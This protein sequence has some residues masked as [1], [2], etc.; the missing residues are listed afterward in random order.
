[1]VQPGHTL[2]VLRHAKSAWP[3]G[4]ADAARPL[5][6][7]GE[8]DAPAVG[9]WLRAHVPGID[10]TVC[11]PAARTRQ[12]WRLVAD[13]LDGRPDFRL[14][15]RIYD[16]DVDDLLSVIHELPDTASTV[17]LVGHNPGLSELVRVLAGDRVE[18]KTSSVAVLHG[19]DRWAALDEGAARLARF[20]TPR[21]VNG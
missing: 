17:V 1:M 7:R 16:A 6:E 20:E 2:V 14:D 13:Q 3:A 18:L 8:R 21:G 11:S 5:A 10:L 4:V 15:E 19:P 12:T 9:Q